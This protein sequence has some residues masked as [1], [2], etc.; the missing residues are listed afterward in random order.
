MT[1]NII[2]EVSCLEQLCFEE[3]IRSELTSIHKNSPEYVRSNSSTERG[4]AFFADHPEKRIK[5]ILIIEPLLGGFSEISLKADH[6]N[7]AWISDEPGYS[8]GHTTS[9]C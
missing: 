8:S 3:V 1:N 6:H 7:F 9:T 4:Y 5:A 2:L